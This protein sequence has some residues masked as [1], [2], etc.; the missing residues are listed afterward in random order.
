MGNLFSY[1]SKPMQILMFIGD[2]IILNF[3]F[4]ICCI[5]IFTI[6]A[7]QSGLYTASKVM[8]D[9]EDDSS[10]VSAFFRGFRSGFGT[11]TL[12]WGLM[13]LLLALVFFAGITA[14]YVGAPKWLVAIG[15]C[16]CAIFQS[17]IPLFHARFSCT[18]KQLLRNAWFLFFAYPLRSIGV[19]LV[20]WL[21]VGVFL[22][23]GMYTFMAMAPVWGALYY[24]TAHMFGFSF[25]KKPFEELIK[26]FNDTHN[27]D[28]TEK[29]PEQIAQGQSK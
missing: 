29:A 3:L 2:L 21:P 27:E 13:T 6:G 17:L 4:L 26:H 12:A 7:A 23:G 14:I 1:E 16:I 24:S 28:G 11:V 15:I 8:L 9:K 25:T 5:P 18:A 10:L 19:T 22:F 20:V